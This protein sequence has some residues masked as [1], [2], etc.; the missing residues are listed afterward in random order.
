MFSWGISLQY[1]HNALD[2]GRGTYLTRPLL[3]PPRGREER[4]S[5]I[6][7]ARDPSASYGLS[8]DLLLLIVQ[9]RVRLII[10]HYDSAALCL[11]SQQL[12]KRL[13][14]YSSSEKSA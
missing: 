9:A 11:N 7:I 10:F 2:C 3:S 8:D 12:R 6:R 4:F 5:F 13:D 1:T 14:A